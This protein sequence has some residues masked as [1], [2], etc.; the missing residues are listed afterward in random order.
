MV[1]RPKNNIRLYATTLQRI[2]HVKALL[3]PGRAPTQR[4]ILISLLRGH[5]TPRDI[6]ADLG[7]T[8][9]A[10]NIALMKLTRVGAVTRTRRGLYDV[11]VAILLQAL[12]A[13]VEELSCSRRRQRRCHTHQR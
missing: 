4:Q 11:D 1:Y 6:A 7:L 9:N 2:E 3:K 13:W 12:L 5:Q 10:V 8:V